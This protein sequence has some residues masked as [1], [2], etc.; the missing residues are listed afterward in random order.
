VIFGGFIPPRVTGYENHENL[1]AGEPACGSRSPCEHCRQ[2]L[3][4]I[5]AREVYEAAKR[6]I[7]RA[8]HSR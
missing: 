2:A 3:E 6:A 4:S 8:R 7:G 1:A 5:T